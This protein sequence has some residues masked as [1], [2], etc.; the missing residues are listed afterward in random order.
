[1][2]ATTAAPIAF[3]AIAAAL[4]HLIYD[5]LYE[6]LPY[7]CEGCDARTDADGADWDWHGHRCDGCDVRCGDCWEAH[8]GNG[9]S[10]LDLD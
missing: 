9:G 1:M 10:C 6:V 2:A 4:D 3:A 5:V 7:G 8:L